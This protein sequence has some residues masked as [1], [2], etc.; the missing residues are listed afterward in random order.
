MARY[1]GKKRQSARVCEKNL[2]KMLLVEKSSTA[3][4]TARNVKR[5]CPKIPPRP[6]PGLNAAHVLNVL[7]WNVSLTSIL[8]SEYVPNLEIL[9]GSAQSVNQQRNEQM[10]WNVRK[11]LIADTILLFKSCILVVFWIQLKFQIMKTYLTVSML[12]FSW[13]VD[14]QIFSD[15]PDCSSVFFGA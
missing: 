5:E 7:T 3:R 1:T 2:N 8:L 13:S 10:N 6:T 4:P 9:N 11:F 14:D 15:M 12:L